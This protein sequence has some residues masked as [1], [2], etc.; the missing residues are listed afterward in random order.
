VEFH[1]NASIIE[2]VQCTN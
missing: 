2:S 1:V